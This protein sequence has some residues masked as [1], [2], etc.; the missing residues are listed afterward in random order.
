[1]HTYLLSDETIRRYGEDLFVRLSSLDSNL[2]PKLWI[3]LGLSGD[4]LASFFA[5]NCTDPEVLPSALIRAAYDRNT[6]SIFWRDGSAPPTCLAGIPVFVIDAAVHSGASMKCLVDALTL[7]GADIVFS[8]SLVVKRTADFIPNYFGVLI[9]EHDRAFFQLERFPNNRLRAQVPIGHLRSLISEDLHRI[10]C[11][12]DL[13][14]PSLARITYSDLWYDVKTKNSKVYVYEVSG[15]IVA[16]V[17][18]KLSGQTIG[19]DAIACDRSVE[20]KRIGSVLMRWVETFAR[21]SRC[22]SVELWAI[23][24]RV[25][26]YEGHGYLNLNLG[27]DL[28]DGEKY[29][30]MSKPVLYNVKPEELS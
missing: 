20:G 25:S 8:Y 15:K 22:I 26:W 24:K 30:K 19:I 27:L 13:D 28:G 23:E 17:H 4:K 7:L 14:L 3:S 9:D 11:S 18:I 29:I 16:F 21:S 5:K 6:K 12:L 2:R 10:P 1:M